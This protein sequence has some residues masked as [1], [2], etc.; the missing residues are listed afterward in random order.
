MRRSCNA[1][2]TRLS[3]KSVLLRLLLPLLGRLQTTRRLPLR[4]MPKLRLRHLLL[5]KSPPISPPR[6]RLRSDLQLNPLK[7]RSSKRAK[8]T[9]MVLLSR[10]NAVAV[11]TEEVAEIVE[12][13][14]TA[15]IVEIV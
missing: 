12:I 6:K 10:V 3:P 2:P 11:V 9:K 7:E 4:L 8:T 1:S 13:V 15:E 5:T 14:E